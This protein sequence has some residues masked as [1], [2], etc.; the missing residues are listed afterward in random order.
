M[1]FCVSH[2]QRCFVWTKSDEQYEYQRNLALTDSDRIKPRK[3]IDSV[4]GANYE[5]ATVHLHFEI[6]NVMCQPDQITF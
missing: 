1:V 3:I 2:F 6:E 5:F 4:K